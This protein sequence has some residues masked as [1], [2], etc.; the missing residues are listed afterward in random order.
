MNENI[1]KKLAEVTKIREEL[2]KEIRNLKESILSQHNIIESKI[3]ELNDLKDMESALLNKF[4]KEQKENIKSLLKF[5]GL[6]DKIQ[7]TKELLVGVKNKSI[8]VFNTTT[9]KIDSKWLD[10]SYNKYK[11]ECI[12]LG[13]EITS[14]DNF[15][16]VVSSFGKKIEDFKN[17]NFDIHKAENVETKLLLTSK[18]QGLEEWLSSKPTEISYSNYIIFIADKFENYENIDFVYKDSKNSFWREVNKQINKN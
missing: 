14:R 3:V 1:E 15:K 13:K 10:E 17:L 7:E 2:E 4:I 6:K 11:N 18:K 12:N 9:N 8:D 5:G 16:K